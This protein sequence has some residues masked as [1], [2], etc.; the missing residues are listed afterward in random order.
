MLDIYPSFFQEQISIAYE[1]INSLE[2]KVVVV[3]NAKAS[4]LILDS[5]K[6]KLK[7]SENTGYH[8]IILNNGES[9][10]IFFS[11][12]LSGRRPLDKHSRKRLIWH[13]K[14]SLT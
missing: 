11:G 3:V 6:S 1:V 13:I 7:Y 9:I 8:N 4:D 10:P 5:W 12:M 2:P 14:R